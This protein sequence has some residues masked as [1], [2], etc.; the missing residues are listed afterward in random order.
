MIRRATDKGGLVFV[1]GCYSQVFP[2]EVSKI[3]GVHFICGNYNK[4]AIANT[5]LSMLEEKSF[6]ASPII[7]VA[8]IDTCPFEKMK[9]TSSPRTRVYVKIEDGCE[10]KCTYCII[11]KARGRIRSKAPSDVIE[12]VR[13]LSLAGVCEIVLTGIETASYGADLNG[14]SL[15]DIIE[16]IAKINGIERI[17]LGS[18]DPSSISEDFVKRA[19]QEKK[20][21]RHFHLSMQS[22]SSSVLARMKRKYN[23]RQAME[24]IELIR[25][26]MPDAAFTTD[27]MVGFPA[28]SENEFLETVEFSKKAGFLFMHIFPYSKRAGTPAAEYAGQ[29]EEGEK[30]RRVK[31]LSAVRDELAKAAKA[32]LLPVGSEVNVLF[33]TW[34]GEYAKGHTSN[35]I[36]V[37]AK[38]GLDVRSLIKKVRIT[39]NSC[40]VC[41][42]EVID[43]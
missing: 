22:G 13:D 41:T 1:C 17:R 2:T 39:D 11:P 19:A 6:P 25:R 5:A 14:T 18:L 4:N 26:Y 10:S 34:D 35:F 29:I 16:E 42:A 20:F 37:R 21:A 3:D 28:E 24:K 9:I 23:A 31:E 12:E 7:D 30:H 27:M 15:I 43:K 8:D 36:E 32:S 33:E 40:T 38:S